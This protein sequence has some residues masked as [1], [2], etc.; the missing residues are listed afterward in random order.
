MSRVPGCRTGVS[1]VADRVDQTFGVLL[2]IAFFAVALPCLAYI[3]WLFIS[4]V[5]LGASSACPMN[6]C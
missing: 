5:F 4:V 3:A 1:P 6:L 2:A